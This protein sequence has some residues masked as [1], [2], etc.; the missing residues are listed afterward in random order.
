MPGP[1]EGTAVLSE[2]LHL[3]ARRAPALRA[4]VLISAGVSAAATV[5]AEGRRWEGLALACVVA[6]LVGA[7]TLWPRVTAVLE[8][9]DSPHHM[10][11]TVLDS[12]LITALVWSTGGS[13]SPYY[14]LYYFPVIYA[15]LRLRLRDGVAASILSACLYTFVTVAGD[16][17]DLVVTSAAFRI[18]T[19]CVSA[20]VLVIFLGLLRKE[21]LSHD[22]LR[23]YLH[24]L[25][26]RVTAVYGVAHAAS[27]GADVSDIVNLVAEQA[28]AYT[29]ADLGLLCVR[30]PRQVWQVAA[31]FTPP[32]TPEASLSIAWLSARGEEALA[33]GAAGILEKGD[34]ASESGA[35]HLARCAVIPL[36]TS[37]GPVGAL[38]LGYRSAGKPD[39]T[40]LEHLEALCLEAAVAVENAQLRQQLSELA[41]T[42]YLTGLYNRREI[43]RRLAAEAE[44]ASRYG[45][46]L[47][48]VLLDID[49]LKSANDCCGHA[50]GDEVIAALAR[51][52]LR[53][54]RAS[55]AVG[56]IGGDEFL[57]VLREAEEPGAARLA[58][59]LIT[60]FAEEVARLRRPAQ[61][62]VTLGL[63]AGLAFTATGGVSA[64]ELVHR[65]DAA[66][67]AAKRRGRNRVCSSSRELTIAAAS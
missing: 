25:M 1:W 9:R 36:R 49:G 14:L 17:P 33:R 8:R 42:D 5:A 50:F 18:A 56:R 60:R 3:D 57:V 45:R 31:R 62:G 7:T 37:A 22:K 28:G 39:P 59:R 23:R 38:F 30:G 41:T 15:A 16:A 48:V 6:A 10:A 46:P 29:G 54:L 63:S 44:G 40:H 11:V 24:D 58:E 32:G 66:L 67:C 55:D 35:G 51:V 53:E 65:A 61:D 20:V 4:L 12:L 21:A 26:C 52:L 2:S 34:L 19:V 27:A 13:E 64:T 43:E 47:A